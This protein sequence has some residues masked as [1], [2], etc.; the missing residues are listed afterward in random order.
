M[1]QLL[2][3]SVLTLAVSTSGFL[4]AQGTA[5]PGAS[6]DSPGTGGG[7]QSAAGAGQTSASKGASTA[8]DQTLHRQ[9]HDQLSTNPDLQNVQIA[10]ENGKVVLTGT[11]PNKNDKKEAK[12]IA[13]SV[14]GVKKVKEN[15]SRARIRVGPA[16]L[17]LLRWE[18]HPTAAFPGTPQLRNRAARMR[19]RERLVH[20]SKE[21]FLR[22]CKTTS[23]RKARPLLQAAQLRR[24]PAAV[25]VNRLRSNRIRAR[26]RR[27]PAVPI[28][29][30]RRAT[31]LLAALVVTQIRR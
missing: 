26:T 25:P 7:D 20:N 21:A 18:S 13:S 27:T 1:K 24:E 17:L 30:R 19:H 29:P 31:L 14:P 16:A 23:S 8:D 12:R 11:V 4:L 5:N 6:P 28:P 9:V 2:R 10:V 22:A 15:I 3:I